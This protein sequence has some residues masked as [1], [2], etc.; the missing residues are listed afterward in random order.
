MLFRMQRISQI[1]NHIHVIVLD[2]GCQLLLSAQM[3]CQVFVYI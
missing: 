2:L 3:A 1:N